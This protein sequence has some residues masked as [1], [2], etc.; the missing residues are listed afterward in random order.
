MLLGVGRELDLIQREMVTWYNCFWYSMHIEHIDLEKLSLNFYLSLYFPGDLT[1]E[2]F[3][4]FLVK[5]S[6]KLNSVIFLNFA[7]EASKSRAHH[8]N[9][10]ALFHFSQATSHLRERQEMEHDVW[11]C[12]IGS[13]PERGRDWE[14]EWLFSS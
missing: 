4:F 9:N 1:F 10:M 14:E 2:W 6:L 11:S 13:G 8:L 12:Y 5:F 3:F 7:S